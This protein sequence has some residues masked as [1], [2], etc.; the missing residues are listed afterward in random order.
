M[1]PTYGTN[2][3]DYLFAP[4]GSQLHETMRVELAEQLLLQEPRIRDITVS[5]K[6]FSA[7]TGELIIEV[8]Y[9]VR[10][11]NNRYNKVYPFFTEEG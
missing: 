11:T 8:G 7:A 1:R 2:I 5:V 9:T 10:S 4:S 3:R 6:D